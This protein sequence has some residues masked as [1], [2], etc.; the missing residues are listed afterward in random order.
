MTDCADNDVNDDDVGGSPEACGFCNGCSSNFDCNPDVGFNSTIN[1]NNVRHDGDGEHSDIDVL[2]VDGD[3]TVDSILLNE[4]EC[5]V[6]GS[7]HEST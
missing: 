1:D 6:M 7:L 5:V 4:G 2:V 3:V